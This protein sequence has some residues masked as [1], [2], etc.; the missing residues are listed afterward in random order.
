MRGREGRE[1]AKLP[2]RY[3]GPLPKAG[4]GSTGSKMVGAWETGEGER[5][6]PPRRPHPPWRYPHG[7]QHGEILEKSRIR[8][9]TG[10]RH[11]RTPPSGGGGGGA[12]QA[13]VGRGCRQKGMGIPAKARVGRGCRQKC[14]GI[15][16]RRRGWG[17]GLPGKCLGIPCRRRGGGGDAGR[18]VRVS[19]AEGVG[20]EGMPAEGYGYPLPKARAGRGCRQKCT[21]ISC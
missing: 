18:S 17:G 11:A 2:A 16:C 19:F 21:G 1:L 15:L 3:T 4:V 10:Y 7:P 5:V 6:P 14:M 13:R 12:P 9:P 8:L 20:G